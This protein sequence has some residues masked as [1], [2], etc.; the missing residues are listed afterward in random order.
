[1]LY[2]TRYSSLGL[3]I[4]RIVTGIVFTFH[5]WQKIFQ[6]GIGPMTTAFRGMGVPLP[7]LIAPGVSI[8]E[9]GGGILLI[10]GLL[11]QPLACLYLID[12]LGAITF[13]H[14]KNGFSMQ[15]MGYEFVLTL[16]AASAAIALAG[17][18]RYSADAQLQRRGD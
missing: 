9:F 13:V 6:I 7:S 10:V 4:L 11:S 8:L 18:G 1:M 16:A 2:S 15:H 17:P 12:M 3:L 14:G 5:G